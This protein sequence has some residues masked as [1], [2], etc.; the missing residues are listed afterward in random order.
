MLPPLT[1]CGVLYGSDRHAIMR[2][3]LQLHLW[4][5]QSEDPQGPIAVSCSQTCT[6]FT[7]RGAPAY[8]A[9]GLTGKE[10]GDY[11]LSVLS[12]YSMNSIET[13][14][15]CSNVLSLN[16]DIIKSAQCCNQTFLKWHHYEG[17]LV[18][19]S[20][21]HCSIPLPGWAPETA[22]L[23]QCWR[24]TTPSHCRLHCMWQ[25]ISH[26]GWMLQH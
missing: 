20:F 24:P 26:Q 16:D 8:T 4:R 23:A 25:S 21:K 3:Q 5:G 2:M 22:P 18:S 12:R 1:I 19:V 7:G 13:L 10:R 11:Y 14:K 17:P 15:K 9:T 6:I